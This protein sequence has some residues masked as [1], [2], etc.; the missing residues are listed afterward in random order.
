MKKIK[1][2]LI[3]S[4][5]LLFQSL[6]FATPADTSS[7]IDNIYN[8]EF[9][10]AKERLSQFDEKENIINKTLDLEIIWWMAIESGNENRF[11]DFLRRLNEFEKACN[12]DLT[13]IISSTYRMRYYA[14]INKIYKLPILF[15]KVNNH[16]EKVDIEALKKSNHEGY[17]LFV[18]Y[19]SF[20]TLIRNNFSIDKFVSGSRT[21]QELIRDIENVISNGYPPNV[22]IGRY[23]LMKYYLDI[24]KNKFKAFSYLTV[25]HKQ[26]P[27]NRVFTQLLTN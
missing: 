7:I 18:L 20:L 12:N 25:L 10:R 8:F 5:L 11:S 3:G 16:I 23:F 27:G 22:T 13:K 1:F 2:Y 9:H 24:E 19:K 17:D 15:M 6:L 4:W 14:C 26:Y 21:R